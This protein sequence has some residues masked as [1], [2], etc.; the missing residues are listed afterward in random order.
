MPGPEEW[1]SR[2]SNPE[3][4]IR[5]TG[6]AATTFPFPVFTSS[7]LQIVLPTCQRMDALIAFFNHLRR[8]SLFL[9]AHSEKD[10]QAERSYALSLSEIGGYINNSSASGYLAFRWCG[11]GHLP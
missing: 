1:P 7:I 10:T 4:R 6:P 11:V 5:L 9:A 2:R 8:A 3:D